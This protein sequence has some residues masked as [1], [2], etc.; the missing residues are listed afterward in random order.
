MCKVGAHID[1]HFYFGRGTYFG[2]GSYFGVPVDD[3]W[4]GARDEDES[5]SEP[6]VHEGFPVEVP[7]ESLKQTQY[8]W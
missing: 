4:S 1:Y 8:L 3:E 6:E 5:R 7:S 2:R